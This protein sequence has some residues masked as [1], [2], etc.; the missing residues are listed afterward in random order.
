MRFA[1]VRK[2]STEDAPLKPGMINRLIYIIYNVFYWVPILL[3]FLGIIDYSTGFFVLAVN[4]FIR[5]SANLYRNNALT[6]QQ[7]ETFPLRSP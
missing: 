2:N 4:L 7:A 3:P 5:L 6:L 1:W